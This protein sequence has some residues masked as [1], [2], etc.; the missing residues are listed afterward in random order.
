MSQDHTKHGPDSRLRFVF[1]D[2]VLLYDLATEATLRDIALTLERISKQRYGKPISI[3]VI[4]P[5]KAGTK[6][7]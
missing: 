7:L 2:A 4:V 3:D 1:N 6:Q 5:R